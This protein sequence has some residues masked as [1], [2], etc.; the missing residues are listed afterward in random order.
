MKKTLAQFVAAAALTAAAFSAQAVTLNLTNYANGS[1]AASGGAPT[2]NTNAGAFTGTLSGAPGFDASPFTTY[3]VQ[4]SQT[5]GWGNLLNYTVQGGSS[6]F[7]SQVPALPS[8]GATVVD[9]LGKLFTWLG[10][11]SVP[12]TATESAAIQLA[13]WES[14]YEGANTLSLGGGAFSATSTSAVLTA[15]NAMLAAAA[16]VTT[17]LYNVSVLQ[18]LT[19]QDFLLVSHNGGGSN[20]GNV[21]EPASLGL[22]ALAL[23]GLAL[24]RRRRGA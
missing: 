12:A 8:S 20:G 14:I 6:Y 19:Q 10:G 1:V 24:S 11:V 17:N 16:S 7:N 21:P 13:V 15:A 5:F 23:A 9:R 4:L 3:C 18:S 22:V 2:F